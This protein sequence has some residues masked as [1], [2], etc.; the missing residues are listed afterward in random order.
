MIANA[1]VVVAAGAFGHSAF[2]EIAPDS[3][4]YCWIDT[5]TGHPVPT[6]PEGTTANPINPNH[7]VKPAI[8]P[9]PNSRGTPRQVLVRGSDGLWTDAAT[10]KLVATYPL[11]TTADPLNPNHRIRPPVFGNHNIPAMPQQDFVHVLCPLGST[12]P[13]SGAK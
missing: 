7:R 1:A 3:T 10:G 12:V 5:K 13:N 9:G 6:Y 8:P 11:G 2:A 4:H